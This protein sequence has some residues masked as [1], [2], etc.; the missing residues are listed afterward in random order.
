MI[1]SNYG[2]YPIP[3]MLDKLIQFQEQLKDEGLLPY[4]DLLGV[5]FKYDGIDARY[6]NTPLDVISFAW[7]G[8]DGIHFGFLT[9]FGQAQDLDHAYIVRVSPMDFDNPVR[10]VARNLRDFLRMLCTKQNWI[11]TVDITTSKDYLLKLTAESDYDDDQDTVRER[12]LEAFQLEPIESIYDY[13]QEVRQ[14]REHEV[15]K[16]TKDSIGIVW[17]ESLPTNEEL[18]HFGKDE[19]LDKNA[20]RDFFEKS[21]IVAKLAFLRDAQ[22]FVILF[23]NPGIKPYLKEQLLLLGLEDETVRID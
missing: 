17:K 21:S 18:F 11:E 1:N 22:S 5:Y 7:P 6:L 16:A 9:D 4:G 12:V 19:I 3:K 2:K 23:E 13:L 14:A 20:V 15:V 8:S 10:I